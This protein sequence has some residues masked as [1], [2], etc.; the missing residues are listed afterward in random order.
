LMELTAGTHQLTVAALHPSGQFTAWTTNTFTNSIAYQAAGDTL[1]SAGNVTQR[2]WTNPNGTTNRIQTLSWD[3]RGRLHSVAER[4]ASNSG[5]NW[6]ATYDALS[7]RLSA[8]TVL[9]SNGIASSAPPV[10]INSYFDPQV[11]FLELGVAYGK[12]TEWKLYGPDLNGTY[13]GQNGT[14]GLDAVSPYLNLFTPVI[15]DFR[16]NILGTVTNGVVSWNPA[17]PTGYGAVPGYRPLALGSSGASISLASAWRGRWADTTGYYQIGLRPYDPVSGRWLTYD[18]VWNERDPIYYT[19][20]GGDPINGFDADGRCVDNT[21]DKAATLT[22]NVLDSTFRQ[23]NSMAAFVDD[24]AVNSVVGAGVLI[25]QGIGLVSGDPFFYG[26]AQ[27]W[28]NQMSPFAKAGYYD[29]SNPVSQIASYGAMFVNPESV[30]GKF[31]GME[32]TISRDFSQGSVV[33]DPELMASA[34]KQPTALLPET[35]SAGTSRASFYVTADGT[36]IPATGYRAVGGSAA[37]QAEAGNLM[38]SSGPTYVTF[39]DISGM[40]GAE[41]K[42]VLQLK[43]EPTQFATF[44]TLQFIDDARIPGGFW[45][46]SPF[47]EPITST[48]PQFGKGGA[49]QAITDT[50]IWNYSLAP[51]KKQ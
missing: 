41:A 20:A 39:T 2:I 35:T 12:T 25:N 46:K 48:L 28:Q 13:G 47:P 7:R 17:R 23:A 18:S 51:F 24:T 1:D 9:V 42:D 50:P 34:P 10:A 38:S 8:T 15:S 27:Q 16:G 30:A 45:N 32:S 22:M 40:T 14:G 21:L 29:Q 11:E 36:A 43:Y 3:A 4:D 5:Y 26:Q 49:T 37:D 6:T 19:F 44:D 33:S 31:G